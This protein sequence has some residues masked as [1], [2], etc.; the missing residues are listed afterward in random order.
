MEVSLPKFNNNKWN[1]ASVKNTDLMNYSTCR[2]HQNSKW[3]RSS[4]HCWSFFF[5]FDSLDED[6]NLSD[7]C[8]WHAR[9][10]SRTDFY[11]QLLSLKHVQMNGK[12]ISLSST[13]LL[14]H[15]LQHLI[16]NFL[17]IFKKPK[18]PL[19]ENSAFR[20]VEMRR[21][22]SAHSHCILCDKCRHKLKMM[23]TRT[24]LKL[25]NE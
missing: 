6:E 22:A 7:F 3:C 12:I 15:M 23:Q 1:I 8:T 21:N 24:F 18:D 9:D 14:L 19:G 16:L 13:A 10:Q 5:C 11:A 2:Q 25:I 4:F 17:E 20:W